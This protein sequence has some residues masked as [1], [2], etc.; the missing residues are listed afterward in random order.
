MAWSVR[1]AVLCCALLCFGQDSMM[2]HNP[3]AA[4]PLLSA[5]EGRGADGVDA[6]AL[7]DDDNDDN[8]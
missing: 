6:M 1:C 2:V 7:W 5:P 8:A 4:L 3:A